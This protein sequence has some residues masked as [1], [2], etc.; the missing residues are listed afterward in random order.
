MVQATTPTFI[1]TL[2]ESVDLSGIQHI[3][4]TMEQNKTLLTKK[5]ND[6]VIVGQTVQ[7]FLSQEETLPF[8]T[9][10]AN[11][12]LNWTYGNGARACSDIVTIHVDENLLKKVVE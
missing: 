3:Y 1:L 8:K 5:D 9:G 2:P 12:Q 6:L 7:V 4:F 10:T 11:I